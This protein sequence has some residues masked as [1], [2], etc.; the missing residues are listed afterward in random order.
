MSDRPP[1]SGTVLIT[2]ASSGIGRELARRV[3]GEARRVVL[4]ARREERLQAL[5]EELQQARIGLDV[6]VEVCDLSDL[7]AVAALCDRLD[8]EG[9]VDVLIN[10]AGF[11]DRSFLEDADW[12]KLQRM[13][14]VNV[15][16]VLYLTHR[17]VAGM[18]AR[19]HGGVMNVGSVL[20]RIVQPGVA[21]YAGSKH[22]IGGFSAALRSEVESAGVTVT[23]VCPGPVAT[24]FREIA[25]NR[26]AVSSPGFLR[27]EPGPCAD[28]ALRAFRRGQAMVFPGRLN[29]V[30]M[31]VVRWVPVFVLRWVMA[32]SGAKARAAMASSEPADA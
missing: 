10:N 28:D 20:G 14:A 15:T 8:E 23:E 12:A 18:V 31:H 30:L 9:G 22:F 17:L 16:A 24:E 1:L 21:T 32:R 3:C 11:G 13:V 2:G 29:R 7:E 4:V 6:A 25:S 5:A 27:I 19:G 26:T